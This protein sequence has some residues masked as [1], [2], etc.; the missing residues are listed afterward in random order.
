M[1]RGRFV[2]RRLLQGVPTVLGVTVLVF[3]L[4]H[5]VPG[6]PARALLGPRATPR[7]IERIHHEFGLDRPLYA[8]YGLFVKRLTRGDLGESIYHNASVRSLVVD[9]L[10]VTGLLILLA[11]LLT[12]LVTVPLATLAAIRRDGPVDHAVRALPVV[13]LGM[14]SFWIGVMLILALALT[15]PI[16][17]AGGWGD[18]LL[19]HLRSSLLPALT[20]AIGITPITIRS[21]RASMIAVLDADFVATA[22]AKGL[23][24]NQVIARHVLRNAAIPTIT[25]LSVNI[26]FLIG[27][28]VVIEQVFAIPG[29]GQ[30]MFDGIANRD[31]AVVQGVTLVFAIAVVLLNI[32]TDVVYSL[33][34]PRV[35]LR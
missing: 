29:L 12:I 17:P 27:G 8:Q 30:L 11:T 10:P 4:I 9:R 34:D 26:G 16:F 14:P 1:S 15:V 32:A 31:F 24:T 23:A 18:G 13:G 35:A 2:A 28:T 33:V 19:E 7:A 22:R 3:F 5:L 6:D 20:I 21:L 25:V